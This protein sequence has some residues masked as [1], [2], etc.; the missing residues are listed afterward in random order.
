MYPNI[1]YYIFLS[2]PRINKYHEWLDEQTDSRVGHEE[3]PSNIYPGTMCQLLGLYLV[4][5]LK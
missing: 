1:Y 3:I 2:Y 5:T 4:C